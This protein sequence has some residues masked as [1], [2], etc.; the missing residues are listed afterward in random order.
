MDVWNT[1]YK[2]DPY[3]L[4]GITRQDFDAFESKHNL[5]LP[6]S[7]RKIVQKQ[8]GGILQYNSVIG[9]GDILFPIDHLYGIGQPGLEDS[10]YLIKEWNL[11]QDI[12]IFSG[13]GNAWFALDYSAGAPSVIYIE[14][15]TEEVIKV[16]PSFEAFLANLTYQEPGTEMDGG[17]WTKEEAEAIFSGQDEY[18]IEEVILDFAYTDDSQWYLGELLNLTEHSSPLVREAI[19]SVI[20]NEIEHYLFESQEETVKLLKQIINNLSGDSNGDI[21]RHMKELKERYTL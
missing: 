4:K 20:G 9:E 19:D 14:A 7:Y 18:L 10:P 3:Q 21:R 1:D 2:D 16:A 6:P 5:E 17:N 11:P 15:D 8:N 13:D 12:L